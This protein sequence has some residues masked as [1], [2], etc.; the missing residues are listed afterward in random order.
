MVVVVD[1]AEHLGL[2]WSSPRGHHQVQGPGPPLPGRLQLLLAVVCG[3]AL[4]A[5]VHEGIVVAAEGAAE[6]GAAAV[7]ALQADIRAVQH[8]VTGG[9]VAGP[10]AGV[11]A[12]PVGQ[13]PAVLREIALPRATAVV[14]VP[15]ARPPA[16]GG[17]T[18]LLLCQG[19]LGCQTGGLRLKGTCPVGCQ[20]RP[21]CRGVGVLLPQQAWGQRGHVATGQQGGGWSVGHVVDGAKIQLGELWRV[22]EGVAVGWL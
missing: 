11:T 16:Q 12:W 7:Y 22:E 13:V 2:G 18:V 9:A 17:C 3:G 19:C 1:M 8:G 4:G 10:R 6:G 20:C 5:A 14:L 21:T 15:V